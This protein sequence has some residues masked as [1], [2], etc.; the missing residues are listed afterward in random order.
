MP[1]EKKNTVEIDLQNL[2]SIGTEVAKLEKRKINLLHEVEELER[3]KIPWER[4]VEKNIEKKEDELNSKIRMK[5]AELDKRE[6][7]LEKREKTIAKREKDLEVIYEEEEKLKD[8]QEE[9]RITK[10]GLEKAKSLCS[11]KQRQAELLIEQYNLKISEVP[12]KKEEII[13]VPNKE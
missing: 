9:I 10:E 1:K 4:E 3:K 7:E 5:S 2:S 12:D 6:V 8:A 13:E 11:E